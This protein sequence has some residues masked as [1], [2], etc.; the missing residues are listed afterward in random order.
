MPPP[1]LK[2]C[3][4]PCTVPGPQCI[5]KTKT[6]FYRQS[7]ANFTEHKCP[8]L[9]L[10]LS[11]KITSS[12]VP[13]VQKKPHGSKNSDI[14]PTIQLWVNCNSIYNRL[15]RFRVRFLFPSLFSVQVQYHVSSIRY[16]AF[17]IQWQYPVFIFSEFKTG[18]KN[19]F[20]PC[21][22]AGERMNLLLV[23]CQKQGLF[24]SRLNAE[25]RD[26]FTLG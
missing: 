8:I 17:C 11:R 1:S 24:H 6:C 16:P 25:S 7:T 14:F 20:T 19:Y 3:I 22:T 26:R 13:Q 9:S 15:H 2:S 12:E 23:E 10:S 21:W 4:R 5:N 18:N